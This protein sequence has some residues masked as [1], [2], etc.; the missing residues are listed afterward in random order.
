MV[1]LDSIA[2]KVRYSGSSTL[3]GRTCD[4]HGLLLVLWL[5]CLQATEQ[6]WMLQHN[7]LPLNVQRKL[8]NG[9]TVIAESHPAATVLWAE[10]LG[11]TAAAASGMA[12]AAPPG[13]SGP[14]QEALNRINS[15]QQLAA[16]AADQATGPAA[17]SAAANDAAAGNGVSPSGSLLGLAG[18]DV[19][20]PM[21]VGTFAP[22]LS[23]AEAVVR[24]NSLYTTWE[25]LC[26][27]QVGMGPRVQRFSACP[28][29]GDRWWFDHM[30]CIVVVVSTLCRCSNSLHVLQRR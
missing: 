22:G 4:T 18:M 5:P 8:R 15:Q 12:A 13:S 19:S 14:L 2:L 1:D 10:V 26:A 21:S 17:D 27:K 20:G 28:V 11:P 29:I 23:P 9:E 24:L 30:S 6:Q 3:H 16:A 25:E 7:L